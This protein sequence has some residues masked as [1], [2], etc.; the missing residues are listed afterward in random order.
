MQFFPHALVALLSAVA[1]VPQTPDSHAKSGEFKQP[2]PSDRFRQDPLRDNLVHPPG[3]LAAPLGTFGEVVERGEGETPVILIAGLG[4]SWRVF[5]S[6]IEETKTDYRFFAVTLAGYG[7]SSAPPMPPA[8]T[9]FAASTWL[10]AS[11]DALG[12]LIA[13]PALER[14]ILVAFYSDAARVALRFALEHP[15]QVGGVL[16]LSASARFPLPPGADRGK[17]MDD[18]ANNWFKTV[19]EVM[20]PSGMWPTSAYALDPALCEKTWWDVLEPALPTAIRYTVE[21]WA[22]DLVPDLAGLKPPTLVLSPGFSDEFLN[23]PSGATIRQRFHG[24]WNA[25]IEA[26]APLEHTVVP[27]CRLLLWE[28]QPAEVRAALTDLAGRRRAAASN[29]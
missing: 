19:T 14:P 3:Y 28:D 23:T 4:P 15:E 13:E 26:G 16:V 8:G 21:T 12:K 22:D 2:T 10:G 7:G 11:R 1:A 9:S 18:F 25:A 17:G 29:D 5:D 27:D 20:W 6:L 24:G